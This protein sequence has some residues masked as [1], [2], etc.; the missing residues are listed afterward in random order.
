V[1]PFL[2]K[3]VSYTLAELEIYGRGYY[4]ALAAALRVMTPAAKR[5]EGRMKR[6]ERPHLVDTAADTRPAAATADEE[7]DPWLRPL[8]IMMVVG[9]AIFLVELIVLLGALI[10]HTVQ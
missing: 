2:P 9:A 5:W 10:A 8:L 4:E 1:R 7:R 3:R 6:Q